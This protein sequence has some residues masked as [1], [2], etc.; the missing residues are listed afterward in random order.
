MEE[1]TNVNDY[2]SCITGHESNI[3]EDENLLDRF[4]CASNETTLI[5]IT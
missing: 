3:E 5:D 1:D 4:R 2:T